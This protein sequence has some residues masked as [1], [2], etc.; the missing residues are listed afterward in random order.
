MWG[1]HIFLTATIGSASE[2]QPIKGLYDPGDENGR[3]RASGRTPLDDLRR[4]LPDGQDPLGARARARRAEGPAAHQEQLRVGN[5]GHRRRTDLRLLRQHRPADG[6][7]SQRPSCLDAGARRLRRTAGL[8]HRRLSGRARRSRHRRPRQ[9]DRIV[10]GRLRQADRQGAL[11]RQARRGRELGDAVHLGERPADRDRDVGPAQGAFVRPERQRAVGAFRH[12]RQR[13][14]DAVREPRADLHQLGVPGRIAAAR[15]RHPSRGVRR[16][17]AQAGSDQQRVRRLVPAAAR[18]LQ[19]LVAR[20]RRS[21]LHAARPRLPALPRREDRQADLRPP[22][23]LGRG[24]RLHGVTLGVQR[25]DFPVERG[26]RHL[27]RRGGARVQAARQELAQRD[28]ARD[29][30]R[31][32][33]QRPHPHA[34]EAVSDC[35][36]GRDMLDSHA[37]NPLRS[38]RPLHP[39]RPRRAARRPG[40]FEAGR[41]VPRA[42][43]HRGAPRQLRLRGRRPHADD[44]AI[45]PTPRPRRK[46]PSTPFP[47]K[48]GRSAS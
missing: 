25:Q 12:D 9:R 19:H 7:R 27:R 13:H 10:H 38:L 33:R 23:D 32:A 16:Y 31:G 1:D 37:S 4:R 11:A 6:A 18:H 34:V 43:R 46:R 5:A 28:G 2:P 30:G 42:R 3:T 29:A 48:S 20:V 47:N 39:W 17:L 22:A 44:P 36:T 26:R 15:L 35:E 8:R 14:A 41:L 45:C 24:R 21:L 40:G